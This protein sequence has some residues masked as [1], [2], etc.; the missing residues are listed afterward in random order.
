MLTCLP[1]HPRTHPLM[2]GPEKTF[3]LTTQ[4]CQRKSLNASKEES[5]GGCPLG[6]LKLTHVLYNPLQYLSFLLISVTM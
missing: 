2:P 5:E 3:Y 6:C 1:T 4:S